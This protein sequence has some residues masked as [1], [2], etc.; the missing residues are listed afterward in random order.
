MEMANPE[1]QALNKEHLGTI[2]LLQTV[3]LRQRRHCE[4]ADQTHGGKAS[5]SMTPEIEAAFKSL[6]NAL[7][8]API[9][10]YPKPGEKFIADTDTGNIGTGGLLSQVHGG[11]ERVTAYY[12]RTLNYCVTRRELLAIV[13]TLEHFHRYLY[14]QEFYLRT[15]HAAL[16]WFMNFKN[17]EGQTVR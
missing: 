1:E 7:C 16:I 15:D 2:H 12:G 10:A 8:V 4:A 5:I 11:Q 14:G 13:R 3:Y 17:L 9:L 6:K